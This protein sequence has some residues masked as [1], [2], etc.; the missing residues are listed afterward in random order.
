VVYWFD[1]R[2]PQHERVVR[3]IQELPDTTW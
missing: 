3:H 1:A 2:R